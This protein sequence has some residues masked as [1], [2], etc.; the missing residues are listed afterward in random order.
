MKYKYPSKGYKCYPYPAFI[1]AYHKIKKSFT[2]LVY[3][4]KFDS[5]LNI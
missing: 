5:L 3:T 1:N 2:Y 4:T